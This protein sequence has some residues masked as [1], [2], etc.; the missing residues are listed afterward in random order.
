[1]PPRSLRHIVL[2]DV[3][4]FVP[5]PAVRPDDL[6]SPDPRFGLISWSFTDDLL[7]FRVEI[8]GVYVP[9]AVALILPDDHSVL[10]VRIGVFCRTLGYPHLL[11][12]V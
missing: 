2:V 11:A 7:F 3:D 1:M 12:G 4:V 10:H 6:S 8:I 5:T 9:V